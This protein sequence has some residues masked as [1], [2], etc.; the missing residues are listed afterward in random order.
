MQTVDFFGVH[1]QFHIDYNLGQCLTYLREGVIQPAPKNKPINEGKQNNSSFGIT[2]LRNGGALM[3]YLREDKLVQDVDVHE[4]VG[5]G[6][7]RAYRRFLEDL[8]EKGESD[9]VYVFDSKRGVLTRVSKVLNEDSNVAF[10]HLLPP[11]FIH[12]E[13]V[14]PEGVVDQEAWLRSELGTKTRLAV[15]LTNKFGKKGVEAHQ[16]KQSGYTPFG[17]GTVTHITEQGLKRWF[18]MYNAALYSPP[19]LARDAIYG[20][21]RTYVRNPLTD[22]VEKEGPESR[23]LLYPSHTELLLDQPHDGT[24]TNLDKQQVVYGGVR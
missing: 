14:P 17:M 15:S 20:A 5:I 3:D 16:I 1:T 4:S 11:D 12:Y 8:A 21:T 18:Y 9:G 13:G 22:R 19:S 2:V 23:R 6:D 24:F 7:S 10:S